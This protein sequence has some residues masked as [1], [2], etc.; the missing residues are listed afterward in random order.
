MYFVAATLDFLEKSII[1]QKQKEIDQKH[2]NVSNLL[3]L[4]I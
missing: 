4:S 3:K 2:W 1:A